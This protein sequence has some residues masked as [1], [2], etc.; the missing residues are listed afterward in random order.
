MASTHKN[1]SSTSSE[2]S[3]E[4]QYNTQQRKSRDEQSDENKLMEAGNIT[5]FLRPLEVEFNKEFGNKTAKKE[6]RSNKPLVDND[7]EL[8]N[9]LLTG[10]DT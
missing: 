1:R 5:E 2:E 3:M 7:V 9:E 10:S 8:T 6:A 4:H